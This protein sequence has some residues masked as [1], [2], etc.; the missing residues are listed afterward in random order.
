MTNSLGPLILD[1]LDWIDTRPRSYAEVMAT[2]R[3]SCPNLPVWEEAGTRGLV[4]REQFEGRGTIVS[5]T[6]AGRAFLARR[7]ADTP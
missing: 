2:W 7:K 1:L 5:V 3:T 6:P 4:T